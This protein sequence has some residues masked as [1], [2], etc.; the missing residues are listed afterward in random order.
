[1]DARYP[2]RFL[3]LG[4]MVDADSFEGHSAPVVFTSFVDLICP[5]IPVSGNGTIHEGHVEQGEF[6][7]QLI[8]TSVLT[9]RRPIQSNKATL[10]KFCQM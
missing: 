8:N 4:D 10:F 3:D 5:V 1:M 6:I 7:H 9:S 2:Q